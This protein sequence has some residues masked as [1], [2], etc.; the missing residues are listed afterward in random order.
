M[1]LLRLL[2]L[3]A[4]VTYVKETPRLKSMTLSLSLLAAGTLRHFQL[5]QNSTGK[6]L[7]GL[8]SDSSP[9]LNQGPWQPVGFS[10]SVFKIS[11]LLISSQNPLF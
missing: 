2:P 1:T 6:C 4:C 7:F 10:D 11:D 5:G 8:C 3:G 9:N